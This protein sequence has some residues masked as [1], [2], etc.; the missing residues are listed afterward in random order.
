MDEFNEIYED[1]I[2]SINS[3]PLTSSRLNDYGDVINLNQQ[4]VNRIY[5]IRRYLEIDD[6][7]DINRTSRLDRTV[8]VQNELMSNIVNNIFGRNMG[9]VD[10]LFGSGVVTDL[11]SILLE[12]AHMNTENFE[13]VKVTLSDNQFSKLTR[14]IITEEN[15]MKYKSDCNI[16]MDDYNIGDKIV[17]LGCKHIF[18]ED[19]IR[20]W[21]CNE[22]VTCPVCRKD[23]REDLGVDSVN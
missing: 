21:L 18:H 5:S 17:Q 22:R 14:D 1:W 19:C 4:I 7:E 3:R 20:N 6:I 15:R 12:E 2:D 10:N 23:T 11:F 8:N 9:N 16:C 13:D